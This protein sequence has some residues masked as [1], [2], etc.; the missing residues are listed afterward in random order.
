[1]TCQ[2]SSGPR[3]HQLKF[4]GLQTHDQLGQQID[5]NRFKNG[6]K[7][8][9]KGVQDGLL[10]IRAVKRRSGTTTPTINPIH[11]ADFGGLLGSCWGSCWAYVGTFFRDDFLMPFGRRFGPQH[12]RKSRPKSSPR[13][14]PRRPNFGLENRC[15]NLSNMHIISMK[16]S[17][18]LDVVFDDV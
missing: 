16:K 6:P 7:S 1:M 11:V 5:K 10:G 14:S 12:G 2:C 17:L 15:Q 18:I 8:C 3:L 9:H 4:D 13:P